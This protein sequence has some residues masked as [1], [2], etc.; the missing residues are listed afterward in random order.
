[1]KQDFTKLHPGSFGDYPFYKVIRNDTLILKKVFNKTTSLGKVI[2]I[3]LTI[4]A[5]IFIF[6]FAIPL[7][8]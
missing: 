4:L 7:I 2:I 8:I 3:I 1:V 5:I 6:L